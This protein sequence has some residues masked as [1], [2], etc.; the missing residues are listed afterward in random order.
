MEISKDYG[1]G[2]LGYGDDEVSVNCV[3][4]EGEGR[5]MLVKFAG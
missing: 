2:L 3:W 4:E 5:T 1:E